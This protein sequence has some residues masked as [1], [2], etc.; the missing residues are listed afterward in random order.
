[1]QQQRFWEVDLLV[2]L[3]RGLENMVT[4]LQ[5]AVLMAILSLPVVI[6]TLLIWWY[7]VV[8]GKP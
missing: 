6:P 4:L 3:R 5:I 1:M 7:Q 2:L 8:T